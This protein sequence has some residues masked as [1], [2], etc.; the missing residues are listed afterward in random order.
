[1]FDGLREAVWDNNHTLVM[2]LLKLG[3][4][5]VLLG[6]SLVRESVLTYAVEKGFIDIAKSLYDAGA[7][8]M[9]D[10]GTISSVGMAD[11]LEQRGLLLDILR[12]SGSR[13]LTEA[14][15]SGN[16]GVVEK[17][18]GSPN[19]SFTSEPLHVAVDLGDTSLI[20][21]LV[22]RGIPVDNSALIRAVE[23]SA[24]PDFENILPILLSSSPTS[25]PLR[26]EIIEPEIV[27]SAVRYEV[28]SVLVE[29]VQLGNPRV[30]QT[31]FE[32]AAWE[33]VRIGVALTAAILWN[34][35][36][37][38]CKLRDAGASL[39]EAVEGYGGRFG[40][41]V[42]ALSALD[43]AVISENMD[44]A[45]DPIKSGARVNNSMTRVWRDMIGFESPRTPLQRAAE[46]GHFPLVCLLL[47]AHADVNASP[48]DERGITALQGAAI[49]GHSQIAA[50][51]LEANAD[52]DAKG[53]E[54]FGRTALE[55]AAEHG[56]LE[57]VV[58]LLE[59]GAGITG[60]HRNQY[61]RAVRFAEKEGHYALAKQLKLH[62]GWDG[63][64][65]RAPFDPLNLIPPETFEIPQKGSE[66][67]GYEDRKS[68]QATSTACGNAL[69]EPVV[70]HE[71]ETRNAL[72]TQG[73]MVMDPAELTQMPYSLH[74]HGLIPELS[75]EF[76]V[77]M[78]SFV[79]GEDIMDLYFPIE[80]S[81][82]AN[83]H[84]H[85]HEHEQEQVA[86][87]WMTL[88]RV[89]EV[90]ED[91]EF[92]AQS[93][94]AGMDLHLEEGQAGAMAAWNQHG[95]PENA[96]LDDPE[97]VDDFSWLDGQVGL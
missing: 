63:S 79:G 40:Y 24:K 5:W 3:A 88:A 61:I 8:E 52:V 64:D 92:S 75:N 41:M 66:D 35:H 18:L 46:I 80:G 49:G 62:G 58:L 96:T 45:A 38:I 31:L 65:E 55:G 84:G 42:Y 27:H 26:A 34:Q 51:L 90:F 70:S 20:E 9:G 2:D 57:L 59:K 87:P 28:N 33:P 69:V 60:T 7:R 43:A 6:E 37:I 48:I 12:V 4:P 47:D 14:I 76:E 25:R 74:A 54:Q 30:L 23:L 93:A 83:E 73:E 17:V 32:A 22:A 11:Y 13:I 67:E 81:R 86:A 36:V 29:A 39:E 10:V 72:G 15:K 77:G 71:R 89:E 78:E 91:Q 82:R 44:L 56:R 16:Q 1:M 50:R 95:Q 53:A 19:I 68:F 85:A 97:P 94:A 21:E